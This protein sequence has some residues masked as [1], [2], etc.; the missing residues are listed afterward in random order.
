MSKQ[1]TMTVTPKRR[2][3]LRVHMETLLPAY[4][5]GA[6]GGTARVCDLAIGGAFVEMGPHLKEGDSIHLEIPAGSQSFKSDA[7]VRN[8]TP[9]GVGIEFVGMKPEERQ[10]LRFLITKLLE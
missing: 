8:V 1:S 7:I 10:Q 5:N 3:S 6:R 2:Q 4:I 9:E